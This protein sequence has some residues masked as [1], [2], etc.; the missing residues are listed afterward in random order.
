MITKELLKAFK[1]FRLIS[2]LVTYLLGAGLVQYVREMR[3]WSVFIQGGLFLLFITLSFE[4]LVL[5]QRLNEVT[6]WPE[7]MTRKDVKQLRLL[8]AGITATLLTTAT[9]IFVVWMVNGV[10][11]QGLIFLLVAYLAACIFYYLSQVLESLKNF[12]ILVEVMIFVIFPPAIAYF[13]QSPVLHRLLTLVVLGLVPAYLAYRILIQLRNFGRDDQLN[14][15]TIVTQMGW[16]KA[17]V[18]HNAL[19]L[20]T[21]LLFALTVAL[22]FPW[23][24]LWPVFLVLP[25]GLMEIWLMELVRRGRKPL[26]RVMLF[27]TASVYLFPIYLL[28]FAFWI[29]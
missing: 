12:Q 6:K 9:S 14:Q 2:Q 13:L 17:M 27:A 24:L 23:F 15:Q 26:W 1:P 18:F 10:L 29:R 16:D 4:Y 3:H 20:M 11:W 8:I 21:F 7:K 19:I 22:G 25:I 28:G 5:L